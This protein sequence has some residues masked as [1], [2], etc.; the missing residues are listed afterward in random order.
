[1]CCAM[2]VM[3]PVLDQL[4]SMPMMIIV[5]KHMPLGV[6]ATIFAL[7][8]GLA[9]LGTAC[10]NYSGV[11]LLELLGGVEA[12]EF[13]N[14]EALVVIRSLLRAL[15]IAFIPYLVPLGSPRSDAGRRLDRK[16][17]EREGERAGGSSGVSP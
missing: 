14:I 10:G 7:M 13:N 8:M 15:P 6:E 3:Y 2:Q 11:V 5:S 9:N 16:A 17:P 4:L 1:V 12:P